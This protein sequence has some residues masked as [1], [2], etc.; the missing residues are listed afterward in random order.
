LYFFLAV[1]IRNAA[2]AMLVA[3]TRCN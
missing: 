1:C 3:E 2:S